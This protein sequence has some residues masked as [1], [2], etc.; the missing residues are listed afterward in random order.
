M[1]KDAKVLQKSIGNIVKRTD[2]V[3]HSAAYAE[4]T[5]AMI[6]IPAVRAAIRQLEELLGFLE[7][8]AVKA[9]PDAQTTS[10]A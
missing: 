2:E 1:K 8:Q 7:E 3:I 5:D 9:Q 10:P 6:L 4:P